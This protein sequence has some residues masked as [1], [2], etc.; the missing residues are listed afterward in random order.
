MARVWNNV[1]Q[2]HTAETLRAAKAISNQY[3]VVKRN[4]QV[5]SFHNFGHINSRMAQNFDITSKLN[6]FQLIQS[7][8]LKLKAKTSPES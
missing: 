2:L 5:V 7:K 6:I 8:K 4:C 1:P 3:R